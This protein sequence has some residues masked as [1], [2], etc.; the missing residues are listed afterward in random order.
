MG[1]LQPESNGSDRFSGWGMCEM[2]CIQPEI[3]RKR[4]YRIEVL[5]G[6]FSPMVIRSWGRIGCRI[7]EKVFFHE[8]MSSAL[9]SAN[10]LYQRKVK[11]GYQESSIDG[12]V[13]VRST[14]VQNTTLSRKRASP[15]NEP[16]LPFC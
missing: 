9:A 2:L 1:E 14:Q 5:Q 7:R 13:A 8:D 4:F 12:G 3:N 11:R 6:L 16:M 10:K 15:N